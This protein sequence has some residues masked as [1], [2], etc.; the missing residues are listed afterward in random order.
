[1]CVP[2]SQQVLDGRGD[3]VV[4]ARWTVGSSAHPVGETGGM[5][6][7]LLSGMLRGGVRG[8][9]GWWRACSAV[10]SAPWSPLRLRWVAVGRWLV[11]SVWCGEWFGCWL[12]R[13]GCDVRVVF[14]PWRWV[15]GWAVC[16][17]AVLVVGG[18]RLLRLAGV[19]LGSRQ[20]GRCSRV[21]GSVLWAVL[22]WFLS[23]RCWCPD[24]WGFGVL[25][26]FAVA[27][28]GMAGGWLSCV[29]VCCCRA[30]PV[31]GGACWC[32]SAWC[33]G[34]SRCVVVFCC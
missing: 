5:L 22:W 32:V 15:V 17:S 30:G 16:G 26:V 20:P 3:V 19:R 13:H 34:A 14:R 7:F 29:L 2:G 33:H 12:P 25:L 28:A 18:W 21:G 1:M 31:G 9:C 11:G 24:W 23:R 6:W 8:A 10:F 4:V 27:F